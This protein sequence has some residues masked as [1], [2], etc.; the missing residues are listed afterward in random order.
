MSHAE[1]VKSDAPLP[2]ELDSALPYYLN[3][4]LILLSMYLCYSLQLPL[5]YIFI[6]YGVLPVLDEVLSHDWVNPTLA[7]M[8][9]L[10][11]QWR[12]QL[13]LYVNIIV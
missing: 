7:Q 8:Q 12:F 5:L 3:S 4:A 9:H 13:P 10:E 1:P 6:V 2:T 11:H